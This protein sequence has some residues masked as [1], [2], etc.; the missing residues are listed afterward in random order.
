M[1]KILI[2]VT[3]ACILSAFIFKQE[4]RDVFSQLYSL[5]G[6]WKMQTK[7]GFI[8]EEWKLVNKDY[9]QENGGMIK[10]NDTIINERVMLENKEGDIFYTSTV[11]DQNNKQPVAFSLSSSQNKIFVFENA[12]HDF[13]KRIVYELSSGDSLHAWID[14]GGVNAKTRQDFYYKRAE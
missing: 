5:Q 11:S 8:F 3:A 13:P 4:Q 10:G 2:A 1:K 12:A 7:K 6:T 14:D 9:L